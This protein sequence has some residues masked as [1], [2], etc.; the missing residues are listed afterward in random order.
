MKVLS[1]TTIAPLRCAIS[2]MAAMSLT[3]NS[4]LEGLSRNTMVTLSA[5]SSSVRAVKSPMKRVLTPRA[6]SSMVAKR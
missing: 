2:A 5:K 3:R 1:T 6:G 4:G